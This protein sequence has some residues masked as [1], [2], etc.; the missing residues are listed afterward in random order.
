MN[1]NCDVAHY[2]SESVFD[3]SALKK[4]LW[5]KKDAKPK[6]ACYGRKITEEVTKAVRETG[7]TE[8]G[9]ITLHLRGN[10]KSNC[11]INNPTDHCY[12]PVFNEIIE[13]ASVGTMT[14]KRQFQL[15]FI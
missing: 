12:H 4:P 11:K 1:P 13:K 6:Y 3:K 15:V 8:T 5:Y 14:K 2:N 7:L 10:T 9:P